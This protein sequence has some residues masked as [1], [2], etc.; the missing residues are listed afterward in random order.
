M[1]AKA[2]IRHLYLVDGSGY[3]F[4]AYFALPPMTRP[5]GTPVNA[6]YGFTNMLIK[7]LRESDADGVAV[8]FDKSARSFRNEIYP[9]YKAHR[10]E[11]PEDLIPQFA[12]IREATRAF[13]LP[14][15]EME[16]LSL[17]HI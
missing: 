8:I 13:N 1:N 6:V 2:P 11:P 10:P 16:G 14:C 4:R 12:M 7:L 3:I 9:E 17:I 15:I 5:D